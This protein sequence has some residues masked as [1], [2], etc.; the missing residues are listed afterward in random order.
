MTAT[1]PPRSRTA[2]GPVAPVLVV[3]DAPDEGSR[4]RDALVSRGW[5]A[6]DVVTAGSLTAARE[7]LTETAF[8][9]VLVD[10]HLPDATGLEA[11]SAMSAA[12]PDA[13]LV[14][15][16]GDDRDVL[17]LAALGEGAQ[18]FVRRDAVEDPDAVVEP[19]RRAVERHRAQ[20]ASRAFGGE[21]FDSLAAPTVVL[22][23]S[24]RILA[25]NRAWW[26]A[27]EAAGAERHLV[28]PGVSYLAA[29]ESAVGRWSDGGAAAGA[30]IREV[31]AGRRES[32]SLDYPCPS[33]DVE[34]WFTMR[35]SPLGPRGGGAV[36]THLDVS[37]LRR[38]ETS[39]R[40]EG[41]RF[42]D[43]VDDSLPIFALIDEQATVREVSPRTRQLLGLSDEQTIGTDA[44]ERVDPGDRAT[45]TRALQAALAEPG[46]PQRLQI[47]AL[48]G[49][50][51]WRDL[52]LFVVN[53][54]ADECV[55]AL[56][57]AGADVTT[58]RLAQ[59]ANHLESR[60]LQRLPAAIIVTD[61]R[62]VIVY[63]NER[64]ASLFGYEAADVLGRS[65]LGLAMVADVRDRAVDITARVR[66]G[67]RWE[68]AYDARRADGTTVPV[69]TTLERLTD[70]GI[71]FRGIVSASID[72]SD[73]RRLEADLAFSSLH[74]QLT[75]LPNRLLLVDQ[76]ES[77]L[78]RT[79]RSGGT[80]AVHFIDLDHFKA[81]NDQSGP[82]VGDA[83]LRAVG[84]RLQSVV[85]E[86]DLV[87]RLGGDE[88]ALCSESIDSAADAV[89]MAE[90][91][92]ALLAEPVIV[93][94]RSVSIRGSIGV[95]LS[96]PD[97]H[98]EVLIRNATTAMHTAKESGRNR[99]EIFDD[100]VHALARHRHQV[101]LELVHALEAGHIEVHF[102]PEIDIATGR[103]AWFEAL[104]RWR[105]PE[106]GL[107]SPDQFIDIAEESGIITA[108][109][110]EVLAQA[111]RA[112]SSWIEAA[113]EAM[114][115]VA[116]NVSARQIAD[117]DF[118]ERVARAIAAAQVP[119]GRLC[120]EVTET[121]L[122]DAG[123]AED[124]LRSLKEI[125]VLIAI[126]DFGTGYS[127]LNRL[128]RLPVDFL[129]IDRSFVD[130]LGRDPGDD[131]IVDAV[132]NLGHSLG[133]QLV[134]EG[135]ERLDQLDHLAAL[136]CEFGQGYLW[137]R[138]VSAAVAFELVTSSTTGW[139]TPTPTDTA[140][141]D[142]EDD[143]IDARAAVGLL[144][145]ELAAPLTA[146]AGFAELLVSTDDPAVRARAAA[147]I[148][149]NARLARSAL[150]LVSDVAAVEE[151]NLRLRREPTA[152]GSV[153]SDAIALAEARIDATL[154]VDVDLTETLLSCD[155]DRLVELL[156][157]LF[158]NASKYSPPEGR[159]RVWSDEPTTD[160]LRLHVTDSGPGVPSSRVGLIF[161]KFGRADRLTRGTGLGL[162]LSRG[163][164][165]AHG[166]D[167]LYRQAPGGGA[168]FVLELPLAEAAKDLD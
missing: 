168:D 148:E 91:I 47:R 5:L 87:G 159:I 111:C 135:I 162:Y 62:D 85:A 126:D 139:A 65:S 41:A 10:L 142:G 17:V 68:G 82:P 123:T 98:A 49:H 3:I 69:Y 140:E 164:A 83:V 73:Q 1:F 81:I 157:N 125:G 63:W 108:L 105:H 13:A 14:V 71:G 154:P 74:D 72:I 153:V 32:F 114:L 122:L 165:R 129:K 60:L 158:T 116:V 58:S 26:D 101:S 99:V 89:A 19:I 110:E 78:A 118:P 121:A 55:G 109:G 88:F 150:A 155:P 57:V 131:V 77:A 146:L 145:H 124:A 24:G 136:G 22:D 27:A 18:E 134:A 20:P 30:G 67:E 44:F 137:Q 64:A 56:V 75:G 96:S 2:A 16:A 43:V 39:L 127:S 79:R 61:E 166:G 76:L 141:D 163:I 23:G 42:A 12:A 161:R 52:D 84:A 128:K 4:W 35:V 6:S 115:G 90:R 51:R 46:A 138:P 151:G 107:V 34:R 117:V 112:L 113:P 70:E 54:L 92:L 160:R 38:V 50:D 119:A 132:V 149:R 31:L 59:V 29:C 152:L 103:L 25:A 147:V 28:G 21:A 130:G 156:G 36:I 45:A 93:D 33:G 8:A 104:A 40:E 15:V 102:Q 53:L 37:D 100:E 9:V 94:G 167:L 106:R 86:G 97:A 48:D 66:G 11:V 95:A 80:T 120:L 133:L 144:A 7:R 143:P